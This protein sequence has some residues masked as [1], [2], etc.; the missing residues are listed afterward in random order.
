MIMNPDLVEAA[1]A[2][3][4]GSDQDG[5]L[6]P[7]DGYPGMYV[8]ESGNQQVR[9]LHF[10]SEGDRRFALGTLPAARGDL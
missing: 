10:F 8:T 6:M 2:T 5:A 4:R 9:A 1:R 3:V 7:V